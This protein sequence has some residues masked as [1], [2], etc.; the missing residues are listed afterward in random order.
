VKKESRT[1]QDKKG[2]EMAYSTIVALVVALIVLTLLIV[3]LTGGFNNFMQ[4][5][6]IYTPVS[7]VDLVI[8]NCDVLASNQAKFEYCCLNKTVVF[9]SKQKV[10]MTCFQA[11]NFSWGKDIDV[12]N[13]E[14]A[15]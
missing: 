11:I 15:C 2:M 1:I 8:Q 9:S 14:G 12:L 13:C 10:D 6:G 3:F 4:K 7:N 5:I